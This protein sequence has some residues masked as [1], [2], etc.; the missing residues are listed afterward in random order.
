MTELPE[1]HVGTA[2]RAETAPWADHVAAGR[3]RAAEFD[4]LVTGALVGSARRG[5]AGEG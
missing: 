4:R 5:E 1:N 3:L 2:E